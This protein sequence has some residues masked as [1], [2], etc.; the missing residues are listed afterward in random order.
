M[1]PVQSALDVAS[2]DASISKAGLLERVIDEVG[3]SVAHEAI[4]LLGGAYGRRV[5]I[6]VGRGNNGRDGL[7]A[8][9]HL[10]ARGVKVSTVQYGSK[11]DARV[12]D[13]VDLFIDAAF[14]VGLSRAFTPRALPPSLRVLSIDIPSGISATTGATL[15]EAYNADLTVAIGSLKP[16]HLQNDGMTSCGRVVIALPWLASSGDLSVVDDDDVR[17]LIPRRSVD[18][19]KWRHATMVLA[20]SPGMV[21]AAEFAV[22]GASRAGAG[23]VHLWLQGTAASGVPLLSHAPE[24]VVMA[25]ENMWA[26]PVIND[27]K[28]FSSI[29]V[30]PGI[31]KNLQIGNLLARL[32]EH[33][34][35]PMVIDADGLSVLGHHER[36][37]R[38]LRRRTGPVVITP[39]EGEF[40]RF[41]ERAGIAV[42]PGCD[43]FAVARAAA[44][45]LGAIVLLKGAPT[46]VATP[47][48]RCHIVTSGTPILGVGGSGDV[49]SGVIGGFAALG[50]PLAL[51]AALGAHVHG[52]AADAAASFS[53]SPLHIADAVPRW[54]AS[55][56]VVSVVRAS[57]S[58]VSSS[59]TV[60]PE[61]IRALERS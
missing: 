22:L 61:W 52:R 11:E 30:G 6:E 28:R 3:R 19:N 23:I 15:G 36:L 31:G 21:G 47:S 39:H 35:A 9:G 43:R 4:A 55:I 44:A 50:V 46:V 51:A 59:Q 34:S 13:G 49:L 14:G 1:I 24:A 18:S 42:G 33:T 56:G 29:V 10:T 58:E 8:A 60:E 41:F 37:Q 53:I 5:V 57:A 48:G 2:L 40:N 17:A 16:G 45:E 32:V 54:L 25:L 38:V 12:F 20:G 27:A 26:E 7:A